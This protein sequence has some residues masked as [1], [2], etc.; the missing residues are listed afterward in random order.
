MNATVS[1]SAAGPNKNPSAM[2]ELK[3]GSFHGMLPAFS[4]VI[5]LIPDG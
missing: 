1:E 2:D 5:T 4:M 3:T